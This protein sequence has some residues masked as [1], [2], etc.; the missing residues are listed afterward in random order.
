MCANC[1]FYS[2]IREV[3]QG[4]PHALTLMSQRCSVRGSLLAATHRAVARCCAD[5]GCLLLNTRCAGRTRMRPCAPAEHAV[6]RMHPGA[7]PCLRSGVAY[8]HA[9]RSQETAPV[10]TTVGA[11]PCQL[12]LRRSFGAPQDDVRGFASLL[13]TVP[14]ATIASSGRHTRRPYA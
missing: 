12:V 4:S 11:A 13:G 14:Q 8:R 3:L 5:K 6:C 9:M 2:T 7:S 10:C 1:L